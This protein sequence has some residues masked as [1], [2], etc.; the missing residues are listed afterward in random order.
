MKIT[1]V[2]DVLGEENNGTTIT[3]KRLI[4]HLKERGH[5]VRVISPFRRGRGGVHSGTQDQFRNFQFVRSEKRRGTCQTQR[6]YDPRNDQGQR[7]GAYS[8]AFFSRE[9]GDQNVPRKRY[10][11][12]HGFP[13]GSPKT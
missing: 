11:R 6:G 7:R 8:D 1:I 3:A 10:P 2:A 13:R 5:A 9:R 4:Q 12:Y